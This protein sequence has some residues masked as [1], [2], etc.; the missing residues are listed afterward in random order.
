MEK[1]IQMTA[2]GTVTKLT[3]GVNGLLT[4]LKNCLSP[5]NTQHALIQISNFAITA[6][7]VDDFYVYLDK[8]IKSIIS[9]DDFY[10]AD[11]SS[12]ADPQKPLSKILQNELIEYVTHTQQPLLCNNTKYQQLRQQNKITANDD[13]IHQWLGIPIFHNQS[14]IG[15]MVV[16]SYKKN[17]SFGKHERHLLTFVSQQISALHMR[18]EAHKQHKNKNLQKAL[19]D[20][21]MI[22]VTTSIISNNEFYK[23]LHQ[24]IN[25]LVP[26]GN[27]FIS[28]KEGNKITFPFYVSIDNGL[29]PPSRQMQDGLT[30]YLL[31][32]QQPI[33]LS[34]SDIDQ[35]KK[36]G[37][38][39]Q[40]APD[41][42]L[43]KNI[44][45]WLGVPLNINDQCIG[46]ICLY[47]NTSSIN[48]H[49][50]DL[51]LL[52]FV[53]QHIANILAKKHAS[54]LLAKSYE[55]L[56]D[57]ITQRTSALAKTNQQ[58]TQEIIKR[59]Q[60][61][62]QLIFN[63]SHDVLTGLPNR[64]YFIDK[65]SYAIKYQQRHQQYI[66]AVFFLDLDHFKKI[67]D[68]LGHRA[69]DD[70]LVEVSNRLK[71]CIRTNDILARLG[72]DEFTILLD[73]IKGQADAI[74]I[75]KRIITKLATPFTF[76]HHTL[77]SG[78]SIGITICTPNNKQRIETII[79]SSDIA[80]YQAKSNGRNNYVIFEPK[81][82]IYK[83]K[84]NKLISEL[85][86][87]IEKK[88]VQVRFIPIHHLV[89]HNLCA[90]ET[91]L[92]W[93]HPYHGKINHSHLYEIAK[94][95]ELATLLDFYI[96]DYINNNLT[97]L[98][99]YHPT[100]IHIHLVSTHLTDENS[101]NLLISKLINTD[102]CLH[103]LWLFFN[104]KILINNTKNHASAFNLLTKHKLTVG[105]SSYGHSYSSLA[106]LAF[107]PISAI[108]LDASLITYIQ[109]P[110][111][112][113]LLKA[114][115]HAASAL[116]LRCFVTG[117][118]SEK[119]CAQVI[120][121]GAI[122]GKGNYI[123]KIITLHQPSP[124]SIQSKPQSIDKDEL[125]AE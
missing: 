51:D 101:I 81:L 91:M 97:L 120:E 92:S 38:I 61:E 80:M 83:K 35:L 88:H 105:I 12:Q 29:P 112:K 118:D 41:L 6:K 121:M 2:N 125:I 109:Q 55:E 64:A 103:Q 69:G 15:V 52:T 115:I 96:I 53:S 108:K 106:S 104:E 30:E 100:Q 57:K 21:S 63:A 14:V 49:K 89:Q 42:M 65:L 93:Q 19:F 45:Q 9:V 82:H 76:H 22:C 123:G 119:K 25:S 67:N 10:I 114:I 26:A 20:I 39:Y 111:Y 60:I 79:E 50:D 33:F 99:Q 11:T 77:I 47:S 94:Q 85:K 24:I 7:T 40:L 34:K 3:Q 1:D 71:T 37:D 110:H 122:C 113:K 73:D 116:D 98:T 31:N 56:E 58:L 66:F 27:F 84:K 72:G 62:Q 13:H 102:I 95:G 68:N 23:K 78:A 28:L 4:R 70:L 46:A 54:E 86:T 32:A 75:A 59:K 117:I 17:D 5:N 48:F 87:A 43:N 90:V 16:Q 8:H 124:L 18:L 44:H 107:L 74:Q 36:R